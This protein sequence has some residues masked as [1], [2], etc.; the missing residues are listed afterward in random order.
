M[1]KV[2]IGCVGLIVLVVLIMGF[3]LMGRYNTMVTANESIDGSWAQVE[4]VLQRRADLIG[5]GLHPRVQTH[6]HERRDR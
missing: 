6:R 4:N 3:S 5:L 1:K 2:M